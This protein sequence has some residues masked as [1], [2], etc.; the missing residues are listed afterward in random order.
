M[1]TWKNTLSLFGCV[2]ILFVGCQPSL[3][4]TPDKPAE[5]VFFP[6]AP[7]MPRLQFLKSFSGTKDLGEMEQKTGGFEAFLVGTEEAVEDKIVKPYGVTL[8]ENKLYV[9]DVGKRMIDVLDLKNNTFSY[10]TKDRRIINP[11]NIYIENGYKYITDP[12]AQ[13]VFVLGPDDQLK[14]ILGKELDIKPIDVVVRDNR[15]YVTDSVSNRIVVIDLST[16]EERSRIGAT[17]GGIGQF[18]LIADLDLDAD[19]NIYAT[20]KGMAKVNIYNKEAIFQKSFGEPGD[21]IHDFGRPKG[22]AV[23][24]AGR[25]WIVDTAAQVAKIYNAEGQLLMFFGF[26]GYG[27]G[28][29]NLPAAIHIDYDHLD[30]FKDYFAEG[31][32]IEFLVL[33]SNQYGSKINVYG[34]GKFPV[35]EK[36]RADDAALAPFLKT[37]DQTQSQEQPTEVSEP[38]DEVPDNSQ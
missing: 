17:S 11:I 33:V 14:A 4:T 27:P 30:L 28:N 26:P 5:K 29:M 13:A 9:C 35:E 32:Q 37:K 1:K 12:T 7:D 36:R 34:F 8:Y 10:L 25:M 19:E 16:G 22:I 2:V 18:G 31:A 15:C 24:K 38:Q 6:E 3:E 21:G 20:D 23:D